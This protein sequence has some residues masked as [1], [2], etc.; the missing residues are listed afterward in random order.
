[1]NKAKILIVEDEAVVARDISQQVAELGYES[2]GTTPRGEDALVLA[3]QRRPDLVL[4]DIQLAGGLDGIDA[5]QAI[6]ERFSIPVVFLTAFA[7]EATLQRAKAAEPFGYIIKPFDDRELRAVIEMSLSKH[8]TEERLKRAEAEARRM[9]RLY[10]TLSQVNQA[11]VRCKSR[12]E[13]FD[14][15]CRVGVEFGQFKAVWVGLRTAG[16]EQV[17]AVAR[18][19]AASD[20][21]RIFPGQTHGCGVAAEVVRTGHPCL[22]QDAQHDERAACCHAVM[23]QAGIPSCAA[24]PFHFH[25]EVCGTL[26]ICSVER[27]GLSFDEVRLLEEVALDISHALGHFAEE[28]DRKRA[29]EDLRAANT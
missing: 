25:G 11:I 24:F 9:N 29:Q 2:V 21:T 26:G 15:L 5:A 16:S 14:Q 23:S 12:E 27:G 3:E 8:Q 17:T 6:R 4:M 28:A 13:L 18:H 20:A 19:A 10:A 7:E 22:S 1:M